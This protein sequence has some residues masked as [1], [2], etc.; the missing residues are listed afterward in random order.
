MLKEKAGVLA[1]Q[2]WEVLNGNGGKTQK[3]IKKAAK[4][5]ADKDFFLGV[6]W[7]LREDKIEA[8]E[9]NG[10]MIYALK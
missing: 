2:I 3:E 9:K 5:K 1:G 8:S 7:L 10:E 4:I 6:G